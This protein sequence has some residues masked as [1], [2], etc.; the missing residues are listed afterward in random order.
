MKQISLPRPFYRAQRIRPGEPSAAAREK[1]RLL[2]LWETMQLLGLSTE[3]AARRV[4]AARSS[5]YRWR[6]RLTKHGPN[7]LEEGSPAPIRRRRPTSSRELAEAVLVLRESHPCWG[8]DKLAILLRRRGWTVS[9]SMVGR[10]LSSLRE[11]GLLK[12]PRR[13]YV[14]ARKRRPGRIYAGRKPKEYAALVPGDIASRSIRLTSDLCRASSSSS[15]QL[16]IW[17]RAYTLIV[18]SY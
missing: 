11:R 12:E 1:Q 17:S 3:E 14:S 18:R 4:G 15:S 2:D 13:T 9:V 7:G 5:L 10:I 16:A 6:R 8:K